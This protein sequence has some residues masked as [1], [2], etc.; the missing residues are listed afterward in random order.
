MLEGAG[1]PGEW[2]LD[3]GNGLLYFWP[4]SPIGP[5]D[6]TVSLMKQPMVLLD[7]AFASSSGVHLE[8]LRVCAIKI[9]GGSDN[10][11]AGCT[12]RNIDS[13]T[14]LIIDG[15]RR[16]GVRSCD[17]HDVGGTGIRIVGGDRL[18]LTPAGNY[19]INNHIYRYGG[20]LQS[21]NGGVFLPGVGTRSL[22]TGYTMPP[23]RDPV[24]RQRSSDR[25]QRTLRPRP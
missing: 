17:I 3:A 7:G 15:G 21:F 18:T 6:V 19:A 22:T 11:I 4:P 14:S 20:I 5:D 1:F 24:L 8:F 25:V 23:F 2:M 13:D 9:L 16:N 10:M 12:I